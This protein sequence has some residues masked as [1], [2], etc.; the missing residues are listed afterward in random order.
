MHAHSHTHAHVYTN[1]PNLQYQSQY[2]ETAA[3]SFTHQCKQGGGGRKKG[4]REVEEEAE[5][6]VVW[7]VCTAFFQEVAVLPVMPLM[8]K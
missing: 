5:V 6:R 2:K 7:L 8:D 4:W 1:G 3:L